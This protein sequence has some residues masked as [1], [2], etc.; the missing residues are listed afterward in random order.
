[1]HPGLADEI[2]HP[3]LLHNLRHAQRPRQHDSKRLG[4]SDGDDLIVRLLGASD[5]GT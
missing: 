3:R 5:I 2:E 1:M 4:I